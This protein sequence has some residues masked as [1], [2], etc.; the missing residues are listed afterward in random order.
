MELNI[1]VEHH[2][3]I[4]TK[5]TTTGIL[6]TYN[7]NCLCCITFSNFKN[8]LGRIK[9]TIANE[10]RLEN[11]NIR[12]IAQKWL[13]AL[14]ESLSTANPDNFTNVF[15]V[16]SDLG[17]VQLQNQTKLKELENRDKMYDE[18]YFSDSR[19]TEKQKEKMKEQQER[20]SFLQEKDP[21]FPIEITWG[22]QVKKSIVN[23]VYAFQPHQT[24]PQAFNVASFILQS[25]VL[26]LAVYGGYQVYLHKRL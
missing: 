7:R 19:L 17:I 23:L 8:D 15:L 18:I 24:L 6:E 5:Y 25:A 20:Y 26:I 2:K 16:L 4:G 10:A 1:E 3:Y 22:N 13:E 14:N 21:D 9:V 12:N 11:S